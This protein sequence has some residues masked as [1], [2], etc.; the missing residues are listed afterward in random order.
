MERVMESAWR[1]RKNRE[2]AH[3]RYDNIP[4]PPRYRS[5]CNRIPHNRRILV[6]WV[7]WS[8]ASDVA[9][10]SIGVRGEA[11][12]FGREPAGGGKFREVGVVV[13][14]EGGEV[15]EVLVAE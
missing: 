9:D 12:G 7:A 10:D 1:E 3:N 11:V 8:R 6:P 4:V 2:Q 5:M 13:G 14:I 15:M